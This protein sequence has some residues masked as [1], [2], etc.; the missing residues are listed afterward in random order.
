MLLSRKAESASTE[1]ECTQFTHGLT[2][3]D[4][5]PWLEWSFWRGVNI[6]GRGG[7][8]V[9]PIQI[10]GIPMESS[11]FHGDGRYESRYR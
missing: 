8:G 10:T 9:P 11:V 4:C 3:V 5:I 2:D 1:K 7:N 6:P